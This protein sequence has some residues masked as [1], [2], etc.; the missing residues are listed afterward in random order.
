MAIKYKQSGQ[1]LKAAEVLKAL[2]SSISGEDKKKAQEELQISGLTINKYLDG[3]IRE[4]GTAERLII[5]F[6][7]CVVRREKLFDEILNPDSIG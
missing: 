5:F 4:L 2:Q 3:E 7:A 6:K 1:Y